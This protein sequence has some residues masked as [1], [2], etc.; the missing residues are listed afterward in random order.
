MTGRDGSTPVGLISKQFTGL[1]KEAFT[2]ADN[3]GVTFPLDL[4]VKMKAV[5]LGAVFLIVSPLGWFSI[6]FKYFISHGSRHI[7][8]AIIEQ[9]FFRSTVLTGLRT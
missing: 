9:C 6:G 1:V 7:R 8:E 5:L 3:F 2:D 4:D